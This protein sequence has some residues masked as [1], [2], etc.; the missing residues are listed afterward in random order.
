MKKLFNL[1]LFGAIALTGAVGFSSCSSS[2]DDEVI[3]NPDFDPVTNTVKTTISLSINP[4]NGSST[5]QSGTNVQSGGN[6]RGISNI[7]SLPF[8]GDIATTTSTT[9]KLSWDAFSGF[10]GSSA[11]YKLYANQNV[12]VG[13]DHFLFIGRATATQ[14]SV[15][16]KLAYGF[17]SNTLATASTVGDIQ[18]TP[19]AMVTS[20]DLTTSNS[21]TKNWKY[22]SDALATYLTSIANA[23]DAT[24]ASKK[25]STT[26]NPSLK[27]MYEEFTRTGTSTTL[28]NAGSAESVRLL[29]T[30]LLNKLDGITDASV[31]DIKTAIKIAIQ[32]K[33]TISGETNPYTVAWKTSGCEFVGFPTNLGLPEGSAQY[34]WDNTTSAFKYDVTNTLGSTT[35][36]ANFVFPNELYY[37]TKTPLRATSNATV[38]WPNTANNWA[39]TTAPWTADT[40]TN[41]VAANSKNIALTYNI[42]YGSALLATYVKAGA[43]TLYDNARQLDPD[44]KGVATATNNAIVVKDGDTDKNPFELT[45]VLVGA[46]PDAVG[47]NFLPVSAASFNK[48]VYDGVMNGTIN[49]TT[50]N[51]TT[52][53]YTLLFD[54]YRDVSGDDLNVNVCLEFKNNMTSSFYG[55]DGI[56]LPGQ[57][58][59]IVGKLAVKDATTP[60]PADNGTTT[61]EALKAYIPNRTLRAFIQDYLTTANF[62]LTAG[63]AN[64]NGDG[65]LAKAMTTIPDLRQSSQTIGLSVDLEWKSGVTYEV[66]LGGN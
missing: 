53:N 41:A 23:A 12:V 60:L 10:D 17:T 13:V 4:N 26:I 64:G 39:A 38:E 24:D 11:N 30:D 28:Y 44:K 58:F 7:L 31:S 63:T 5:R 35:A 3:N 36:V 56:I 45:G 40:W 16:D 19:G 61:D 62:T 1:A 22:Q 32:D 46:Q 42:N 51:N 43:T 47:W 55:K 8:T 59:Y 49:V 20:E 18:V 66:D 2:S 15:A 48:V 9:G 57:K 50:T 21:T 6:F 54:N 14:S 33:A 25:W 29:L 65:S 52:P 34:M 27:L 37:L